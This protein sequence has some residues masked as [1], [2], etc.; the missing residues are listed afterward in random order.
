MSALDVFLGD[1]RVGLLEQLGDEID[2]HRFSPDPA[3]LAMRD[4]PI[5]GQIVEDWLPDP[6]ACDGGMIPWFDH[7]LPLEDRPLRRAIAR[8]AGVDVGD[9]L[10]LLAWLGDDLIGAVRLRVADGAQLRH[11]RAIRRVET[12]PDSATYRTSLPGAQWKLSL[13]ERG[14]ALSLPVSGAQGEWI[15]KFH[16]ESNAAAVRHEYATMTWARASGVSVPEI[17]W[18]HAENIHG[19]PDDVPR[20]NGDVFLIRRFDRGG[21]GR[22]IHAEDFAQ[23]LD[24]P[25]GAKQFSSDYEAIAAVLAA[26]CPRE[27]VRA[28]VRQ[29][30]FVLLS[31]NDDAHAKNWSLV[32]PD[33]VRARLSPAYDLCPTALIQ[34]ATP[35][36]ALRLNGD[37]RRS[38]TAVTSASFERLAAV[39]GVS[40]QE[41]GA[42]VR[43]D[44]TRVRDAWATTDARALFLDGERRLLERHMEHVLRA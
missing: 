17:R 13:Q 29:L 1:L 21:A 8:D 19:L 15:G 14:G 6:K 4:R 7:L 31:G 18:V 39:T 16:A 26:L 42:W 33:G 37:N 32:Y 3:W 28:F 43:D 10:A 24:L 41:M 38:F 27:D 25:Q 30:V 40:A 12:A 36:L 20:G 9:A 22:R 34:Q 23:I 5:L 11:R 44:A 35:K 2:T